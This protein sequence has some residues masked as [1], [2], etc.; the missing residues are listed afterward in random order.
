MR[1]ALAL[2]SLGIAALGAGCAS[3]DPLRLYLA[4]SRVVIQDGDAVF[5]EYRA[6]GP[7][8]PAIW[9]LCAP[10][11]EPVTRAY[12]FF[13]VEGEA[14]DHPHHT[15]FW[16]AHGAVNG[17]DFWQGNGRIVPVSMLVEQA[18]HRIEQACD[19]RDERGATVVH[20]RREYGFHT[21]AEWRAVDF[22]TSLRRDEGPF[23]FGDTKEG[24]LALRLRPEFCLEGPGAAGRVV[25]SEGVVG[26]A[27]WGKPARWVAYAAELGGV[28]HTVALFDHPLNHGHP[29]TWHARGYGLCAANP[30]GLSDFA[31]APKGTGDLVVPQGAE[32][33]LRY[34]VWLHRGPCDAAAIE[35]AWRAFTARG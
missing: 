5:A 32:L 4:G 9:P 11:G 29:T 17:V 7:R 8:G 18:G 23:T 6:D 28:T 34:R 2:L 19:W 10:G 12:P 26:A 20:E 3:A 25:N 21:G 14:Q 24:T 15:S 33:R 22:A 1:R 16:F 13:V 31:K 27:V 35:A 30:F